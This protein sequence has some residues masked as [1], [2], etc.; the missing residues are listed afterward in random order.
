MSR[1]TKSV[2]I[3][4]VLGRVQILEWRG[5]TLNVNKSFRYGLG[6]LHINPDEL[7]LFILDGPRWWF[8]KVRRMTIMI[9]SKAVLS[10]VGLKTIFVSALGAWDN[11]SLA[12]FLAAV[13]ETV[14]INADRVNFI[15]ISNYY[16][17]G[18]GGRRFA[19]LR[20]CILKGCLF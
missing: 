6:F 12:S 8:N 18:G 9:Y 10:G 14:Q 17:G 19:K 7:L 11:P 15:T 2:L 20:N 4:I 16:N 1:S 5:R 3:W 13:F